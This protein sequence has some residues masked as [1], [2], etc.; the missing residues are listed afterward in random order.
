MMTSIMMLRTQLTM[1]LGVQFTW[2]IWTMKDLVENAENVSISMQPLQIRQVQPVAWK[3]LLRET[4]ITEAIQ[5][6]LTR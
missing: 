2:V 5:G 4:C 6:V 1:R 3:T